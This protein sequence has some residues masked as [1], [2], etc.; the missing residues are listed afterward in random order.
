MVFGGDERF[1]FKYEND[2]N[3]D[4]DET[5]IS[6]FRLLET[7]FLK[8]NE[9]FMELGIKVLEVL[10]IASHFYSSDIEQSS[11]IDLFTSQK[12]NIY[13]KY[14]KKLPEFDA[15]MQAV[16][17]NHGLSRDDR[18]F[19]YDIVD[20]K[21]IP[22]YYDGGV[23]ILYND[24]FDKPNLFSDLKLQLKN[25][26]KFLNSSHLGASKVLIKLK[27]IDIK[28]FKEA[29]SSRG[30]EITSSELKSILEL[31]KNNLVLLS[32]LSNNELI[33]VSSLNQFSI[34]N[35]LASNKNINAKYIFIDQDKYKI[36]DLLLKKCNFII[37]DKFDLLK[38][39]NQKLTDADGFQLIFL[40]NV[41][42]FTKKNIEDLKDIKNNPYQKLSI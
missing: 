4:N 30:L 34:K 31:I 33:N 1:V 40:G 42:N 5:G 12:N 8:N 32:N 35:M 13:E 15:L 29:L 37:L 22:I 39:I 16:G 6:K 28:N 27:N 41:N 10:N 9:I 19:Y 18:R 21:F 25:K 20:N 36:C 24:K 17:A 38:A 23:N 11:F 3:L 2:D 14:F 7:K 26:K